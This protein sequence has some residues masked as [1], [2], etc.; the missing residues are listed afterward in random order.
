MLRRLIFLSLL[1]LVQLGLALGLGLSSQRLE[2]FN[3]TEK[4]LTF[5]A[6]APDRL[7]FSDA[8]KTEITLQ[9]Q[10]S[11][12]TLPAR[13]GARADEQKVAKL[14]QTLLDLRRPW[15][16]AENGVTDSRFKVADDNFERRLSFMQGDKT[17]STL[18]VGSSPGFRKVYLRVSG[19]KT[20]YA[21]PFS[22]YQASLK[23]EDWIDKRQLQVN[24]DQI[25]SIELPFGRLTRQ[26]G[27][28]QLNGLNENEQ[29]DDQKANALVGK[30][31]NLT[32]LDI[33][34]KPEQTLARPVEL[35]FSL[36]LQGGK[37]RSYQLLKGD[38]EGELLLQQ[39][40]QPYLYKVSP[41]L[42]DELLS[43]TRKSLIKTVD[44][45][46][47]LQNQ[48]DQPSSSG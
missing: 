16:V 27:G 4:L 32:I 21:L 30:L 29:T 28:F 24:V 23:P 20:V 34:G 26:G 14:L 41:A 18:L 9:K 8:D 19:E 40:D 25:S 3:A 47:P 15:P 7:I 11:S 48:E 1:L 6:D 42:Q 31:A 10:G 45:K 2:A 44:Q 33:V 13:F 17:L 12:W 38:Q 5:S 35:S 43:Y 36:T 37:I 22:S 39:S 46:E